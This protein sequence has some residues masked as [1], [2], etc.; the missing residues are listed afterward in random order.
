MDT[1]AGYE[2]EAENLQGPLAGVSAA[3]IADIASRNAFARGERYKRQGRVVSLRVEDGGAA[4]RARVRGS[5]R[6]PYTVSITIGRNLAGLPDIEGFCSCPVGYNCKHVVAAL[7]KAV[8]GGVPQPVTAAPAGPA[9]VSLAPDLAAWI[10]RLARLRDSETDDYPPDVRQRLIYVLAPEATAG[11]TARWA[12]QAMS[13]RL[14]KD[15][16]FSDRSSSY[17]LSQGANPSPPKF[18]RPADRDIIRRLGGVPYYG[19]SA[20]GRTLVGEAGAEAL[21]AMIATRRAR[22]GS[23]LGPVLARGPERSGRIGWRLDDGGAHRTVVTVEPADGMQVAALAPPWYVEVATGVAG[24]VETGLPPRTAEAILAAPPVPAHQNAL[25][26]AAIE[27]R[28]PALAGVVPPDAPPVERIAGPPVPGLRFV[29]RDVSRGDGYQYYGYGWTPPKT[30]VGG[31]YPAVQPFFRYGAI[32][33]PSGDGRETPT[34]A[35][36]G[37]LFEVTRDRRAERAAL[38]RLEGVGFGSV[39]Y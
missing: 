33:V 12:V 9:P 6:Q 1:H 20:R 26:R 5:G 25:V 21:A 30:A 34:F 36:D 32:E 19:V 10:D 23:L 16:S 31:R 14:L 28:Y 22:W 37:R 13:V 27:K 8:D 18:L 38:K 2:N 11:G 24:P 4:L 7:L 15:G 17:D 29:A 39:P 3:D 35:C